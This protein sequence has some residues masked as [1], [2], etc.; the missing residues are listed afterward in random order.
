MLG[1]PNAHSVRSPTAETTHPKVYPVKQRVSI[2]LHTQRPPVG[3]HRGT[4]W[5]CEQT[6]SNNPLPSRSMPP[7]APQFPTST[8]TALKMSAGWKGF[9]NVLATPSALAS[10]SKSRSA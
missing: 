5:V 2:I 4:L 7:N 6:P 8:R 1:A 9:V 3:C 10:G